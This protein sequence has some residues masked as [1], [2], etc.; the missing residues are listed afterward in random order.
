MANSLMGAIDPPAPRWSTPQ[1][2]KG[3]R[4]GLLALAALELAVAIVAAGVHRRAMQTVGNDTA[5]SILAAQR[6]KSAL[7]DMDASAANE[8]LEASSVDDY[9]A[10]REEAARALIMAAGNITF[11]DA[12]RVPILTLQLGL[13]TYE[14]A[15]QRA[16]D[17][18]E[19]NDPAFL[20]SWREGAK[21]V[22]EKLLP[23]ADALDRANNAVLEEQYEAQSNRSSAMRDLLLLAGLL[24]I[25]GLIAA[26]VFLSRR[27][28]R[29]LNAYLL[30][31]TFVAAGSLV[32]LES[33]MNREQ[34]ALRIAKEDAFTSI[35]TLWRARADAFWANGDES[36]YLLDSANGAV[37][38][39]SFYRKIAKLA[40]PPAGITL[41]SVL[42]AERSGIKT[43]GFT[44]F[45]SEEFDN[46]TFQGERDAAIDSLVNL[47]RYME[48]DARIRSMERPALTAP[49]FSFP[50]ARRRASPT[51][52]STSSTNRSGR[53]ST[54]T[55]RPSPQ[56]W[57][58]AFQRCAGWRFGPPSPPPL[59]PC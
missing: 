50:S 11:G 43:Q 57:R 26:Q 5:P 6:I 47:I 42:Q 44:G 33:S 4:L 49:P 40:S 41:Q 7:A 28:K 18:H 12:E 20:L 52:L 27:M 13:G 36:R 32:Y 48:I 16:R 53:P 34:R 39:Q 38:E 31:A 17:L 19:R 15:I 30:A 55:S 58:A 46:I 29:L 25:A 14:R 10:R 3:S 37:Y 9:D 2:L 56:P 24:L 22:D 23:A 35:R 45:L 8:L 1:I 51:G 59:S 54:S 21:L